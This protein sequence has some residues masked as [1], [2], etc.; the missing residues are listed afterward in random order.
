MYRTEAGNFDVNVLM[1]WF[2]RWTSMFP[3]WAFRREIIIFTNTNIWIYMW[4]VDRFYQNVG[5][6]RINIKGKKWGHPL[7]FFGIDA[8]CQNA[9]QLYK[10]A[11]NVV[12]Q[13]YG[14]V[15]NPINS[16]FQKLTH[17]SW[18]DNVNGQCLREII[19]YLPGDIFHTFVIFKNASF[20]EAISKVCL[21]ECPL[22][23]WRA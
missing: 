9:R 11:S 20:F 5:S 1:C 17:V 4:G 19:K 23:V 22:I 7:F 14:G 16:L 6:L 18:H 21:N 10:I 3:C 8:A 2:R 13:V 15:R 12:R